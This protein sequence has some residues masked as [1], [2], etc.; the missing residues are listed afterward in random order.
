MD[1]FR[2]PNCNIL[3]WHIRIQNP[4]CKTEGERIKIVILL[5]SAAVAA[6]A[7]T[8]IAKSLGFESSNI[9]GGGAGGAVGSIVWLKLYSKQQKA[10]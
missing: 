1:I 7:A 6:I 2:N 9:I 4:I 3:F 5:V 8:H 10:K